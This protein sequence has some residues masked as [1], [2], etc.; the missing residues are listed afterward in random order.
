LKQIV[1]A[2]NWK[3]N[4]TLD[5]AR[6]LVTDLKKNLNTSGNVIT[7]LCPPFVYLSEIQSLLVNSNIHIGAQ[8]IYFEEK[9]AFTGEISASMVSD[10]C[11]FVI[12][13]HSERRSIFGESN[14]LINK[15]IHATLQNGLKPILCVG[16]SQ[17]QRED[18]LAE[19]IIQEQL[20]IGL[21]GVN[22]IDNIQ[23]AYEPVWA[24][25]TG[26]AATPVIANE[27]MGGI[28][29]STLLAM[30]DEKQMNTVPLLYGGS[31][32]SENI[33]DYVSMS[34]IN[35]ALIGGASLKVKEFTSIVQKAESVIH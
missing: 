16:E 14:E 8:N 10:F 24:I 15:K 12:L 20:S 6:K 31:V 22:R 13:G 33:E 26:I 3:M 5:E 34:G 19:Q 28:I 35:G 9:G 1:I 29:K 17:Q 30:Y 2:A 25:G 32:N 4:T 11:E 7:I 27:I 23:I 18:G 21:N